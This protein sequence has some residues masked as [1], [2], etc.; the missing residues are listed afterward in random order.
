MSPYKI[1]KQK[2]RKG[3]RRQALIYKW[4]QINLERMVEF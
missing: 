1:Q 2:E 3:R 4:Q